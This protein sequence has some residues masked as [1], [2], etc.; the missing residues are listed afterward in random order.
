M[1]PEALEVA[2]RKRPQLVLSDILMPK[3]DGFALR[4]ALSRDLWLE[5]MPVLLLS[6]KGDPVEDSE[7]HSQKFVVYQA[8]RWR[9]QRR[10]Q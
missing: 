5:R 2:R 7:A 4:R 10:R 1:A 9:H 6:W 8:L 3:L